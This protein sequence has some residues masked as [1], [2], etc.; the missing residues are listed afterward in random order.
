MKFLPNFIQSIRG[1]GNQFSKEDLF[2]WVESVDDQAHQLSDL[3][4]ECEGLDVFR[5]LEVLFF[6][7]IQRCL[8]NSTILRRE[9]EMACVFTAVCFDLDWMRRE[10]MP[11]FIVGSVSRFFWN[12]LAK[13]ITKSVE[14]DTT[15]NS[16]NID[17]MKFF[18]YQYEILKRKNVI[19]PLLLWYT[20]FF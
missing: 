18:H 1:I 15:Y 7:I 13:I 8:R 20:F 19:L 6:L 11:V 10:L 9:L 14:I 4:L 5:H 3:G 17:E 16:L 2:V 12:I